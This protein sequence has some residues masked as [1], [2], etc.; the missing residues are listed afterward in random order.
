MSFQ[1]SAKSN[2]V[3]SFGNN[4]YYQTAQ[5]YSE[6]IMTPKIIY[7][8][9]NKKIKKIFSGYDYNFV[10]DEKNILYSWGLNTDGQ[11]GLPDKNVIQSPTE[12]KIPEL[13]KEEII[14]NI[15]CGNN[16]TYFL[17]NKNKIYLC[18][19]NILTQEKYFSPKRIK[20]FFEEEEIVQIEVGENFC[21]FLTKK[22]NVYSF[23]EGESYL[24]GNEENKDKGEE[25]KDREEEEEIKK[26]PKLVMNIKNVQ[27][28][29]CGNNHC[30]AIDKNNTIFCWGE[31][32][33]GQL[34]LNNTDENQKLE[35]NIIY[36]PKKLVFN[37][38]IDNIFCGK[39]FT[40]FHTLKNEILVCGN[41]ENGQLGI[42]KEVYSESKKYIDCMN[43][44]YVEQFY[45]LEI[46][47]VVC[48]ENNCLA[49]VKDSTNKNENIWSWGS[50]K[51]GQLGLG[52]DI[53]NSKP[54][55]IPSFFEYINHIPKD[56]SC[57]KN[58][59]LVLLER[60]DEKDNINN[61]KIIEDFISKYNKF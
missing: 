16:I 17:S 20:Y 41:N 28:I 24:F 6:N 13:E 33:R 1:K 40:I 34:G 54:K 61:K 5:D 7:S 23:G 57:G 46:I 55:P 11:C 42:E 26:E 52:N 12:I 10:I 59:C 49:M 51:E 44:T 58:H 35:E 3:I 31:N 48:G 19:F 53:E 14:I 45:N 18:G 38:V 32:I 47:K 2:I 22:G 9:I 29:S 8:L 50:N 30:F 56:I 60:K 21:L 27:L 37:N 43:P 36:I 15:S 4:N 39:D 25:P